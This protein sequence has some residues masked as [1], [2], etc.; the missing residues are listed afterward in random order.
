MGWFSSIWHAVK[1]VVRVVVRVVITIVHAI[2][3]NGLD[4]LF[5]MFA[6]PPK[7]MRIQ[8]FVLKDP[9]T[10]KPVY[11]GANMQ[12]SIQFVIDTFKREFNV[13]VRPYSKDWVIQLTDTPPDAALNPGCGSTLLGQEFGDGGNYY[14]GHLAGWNAIPISLTYPVTVFVVKNVM[15]KQGCSL[16][17]LTDYVVIDPD[18]ID[19]VNTMAH[20]LGHSC[21]LW[22]SQTKINLMWADFDRGSTSK[23]FQRNLLRC[24]RHINYF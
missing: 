10:G 14:A 9:S 11:S 23:W 13:K 6:W 22:H 12:P 17:P 18:G 7:K 24:S 8:I 16:G 4:L 19:N 20:E 21:N 15:G 3:P 1:A 2:I 5:G